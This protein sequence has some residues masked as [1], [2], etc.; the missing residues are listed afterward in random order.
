MMPT[1]AHKNPNA[2]LLLSCGPHNNICSGTEIKT[3]E[4]R[5]K[6]AVQ[7]VLCTK[8][9]TTADFLIDQFPFGYAS[10]HFEMQTSRENLGVEE[11]LKAALVPT[12]PPPLPGMQAHCTSMCQLC[13]QIGKKSMDNS[14]L[15]LSFLLPFLH[16]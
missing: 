16:F 5:S 2:A 6:L 13:L 10:R 12:S 15:L 1:R 7:I 11:P 8:F 3:N 4:C 14:C 9:G